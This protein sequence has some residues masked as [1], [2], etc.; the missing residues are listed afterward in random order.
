MTHSLSKRFI[1][2]FAAMLALGACQTT[3]FG[4]ADNIRSHSTHSEP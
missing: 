3:S 1:M 2:L 4:P